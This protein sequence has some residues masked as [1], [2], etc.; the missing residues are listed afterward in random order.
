MWQLCPNSRWRQRFVPF[1]RGEASASCPRSGF[2]YLHRDKRSSLLVPC[3]INAKSNQQMLKADD[4]DRNKEMPVPS[5]EKGYL[6]CHISYLP[7]G[8]SSPVNYRR[9][10]RNCVK[11][12]ILSSIVVICKTTTNV[13]D[14][15]HWCPIASTIIHIHILPWKWSRF[16][17]LACYV[18]FITPAFKFT[19]SG[20]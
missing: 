20:S 9:L 5:L 1:Q 10:G 14:S 6:R 8:Q 4:D 13:I 2:A 7:R 3:F 15:F 11:L 19:T 16:L 12:H 17:L 18:R